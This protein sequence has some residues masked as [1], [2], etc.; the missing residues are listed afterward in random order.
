MSICIKTYLFLL[1]LYLLLE[2][3]GCLYKTICFYDKKEN[4]IC[5]YLNIYMC[6]TK[7]KQCRNI[8]I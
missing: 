3:Y 6:Q 2:L 7:A 5:I 1:F 8:N 4:K